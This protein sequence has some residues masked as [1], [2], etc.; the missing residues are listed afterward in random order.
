MIN[1]T[2]K[3]AIICAKHK[4]KNVMLRRQY[5]VLMLSNAA[6]AARYIIIQK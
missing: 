1:I 3:Y 6:S 2:A 5:R 4:K